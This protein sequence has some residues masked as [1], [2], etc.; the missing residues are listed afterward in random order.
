MTKADQISKLKCNI[1]LTFNNKK[2]VKLKDEY[3]KAL[4]D[5]CCFSS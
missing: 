3:K 5:K 2:S 4:N 1:Y